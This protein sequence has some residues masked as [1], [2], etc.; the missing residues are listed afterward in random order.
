MNVN[1]TLSKTVI[2]SGASSGI[3]LVTS[4]LFLERGWRVFDLSRRGSNLPG[5]RHVYCDFS[6][7][8]RCE[9]AIEQVVR[10]AGHIH[11]KLSEHSSA[12]GTALNDSLQS[13][14][15]Y[16]QALDAQ[17]EDIK[18][19]MRRATPEEHAELTASQDSIK[20]LFDKRNRASAAANGNNAFGD[21]LDNWIIR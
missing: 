20:N 8:K 6:E 11:V 7:D 2:I 1:T 18:K 15:E 3:G 10:E 17:L 14:R 21:F 16:K 13:W 4:K 9:A 19:K 12:S 5:I